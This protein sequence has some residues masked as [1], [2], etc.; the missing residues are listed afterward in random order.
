MKMK[1]ADYILKEDTG[2]M[3]EEIYL[4]YVYIHY[5]KHHGVL[6]LCFVVDQI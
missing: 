5:M 3:R 1:I 6:R 2:S 4:I